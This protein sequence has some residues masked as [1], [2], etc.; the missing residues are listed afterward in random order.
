MNDDEYD[1]PHQP[2]RELKLDTHT[3]AVATV[4]DSFEDDTLYS[5]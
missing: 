3:N 5:V 1:N 2:M 4:L